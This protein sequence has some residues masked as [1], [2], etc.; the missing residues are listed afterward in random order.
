MIVVENKLI[1]HIPVLHIAKQ[2]QFSE[3]LPL[4]LFLHGFGSAKENNLHYAYLLAEKGFR[5]MLPEALHH[6]ERSSEYQ[7]SEL[8]SRFWE[9]VI[10]SIKDLNIIKEYSVNEGIADA[11][12]IGA[13]GT[14]MGGIVTLGALTQY[15]WIKAAVSL[16]GMPYYEKFARWQL[17]DLEKQ[18]VKLSLTDKQIASLLNEVRKYDLTLQPEK[19]NERPLLFWHGQKDPVVPYSFTHQFYQ[20]ITGL[21]KMSPD[22]LKFISDEKA[23]HKVSLLGVK[24]TVDWF[25]EYL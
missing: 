8:N 5:V 1:E 23:E 21:Y 18:G 22:K 7:K 19:L 6:G 3:K 25:V 10:N 16:M 24:S 9:V 11:E 17:N 14:S 13:A 12:R 4:V 20:E 2:D 15:E